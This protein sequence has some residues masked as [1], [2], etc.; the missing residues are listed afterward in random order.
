M[1]NIKQLPNNGYA[2]DNFSIANHLREQATWIEEDGESIRNVY[3]IIETSDGE[4]RRQTMGM[5]CDMA[6][7]VG[8]LTVA[9]AQ[10]ATMTDGE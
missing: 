10:A 9:A 2:P 7:I 6:R 5:P 8:I 1:E 4:L 3:L